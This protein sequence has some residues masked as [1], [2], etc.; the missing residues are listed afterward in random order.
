[1][2][3]K[4]ALMA[5]QPLPRSSMPSNFLILCLTVSADCT[6]A[7]TPQASCRR[8]SGRAGRHARR[9][10]RS[11]RGTDGCHRRQRQH[12]GAGL[13]GP[14][15][16]GGHRRRRQRAGA[17]RCRPRTGAAHG[18][19]RGDALSGR[20]LAWV[21]TLLSMARRWF[22]LMPFQVWCIL[23]QSCRSECSWCDGCE[24]RPACLLELSLGYITQ[25][26]PMDML[27]VLPVLQQVRQGARQEHRMHSL[28]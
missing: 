7:R 23:Q 14:R 24:R 17:G 13:C 12:D 21:R 4:Y 25:Y 16:C 15:T 10:G 3:N 6:G 8:G 26:L 9:A 20:V 27:R 2:R 28:P 19:H 5:H 1:M 22:E 18:G 11:R